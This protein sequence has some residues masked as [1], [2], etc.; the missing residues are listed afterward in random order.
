MQ[1]QELY[2]DQLTTALAQG[3][4][5]QSHFIDKKI[6]MPREDQVTCPASHKQLGTRNVPTS[7]RVTCR[8]FNI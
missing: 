3:Y 5:Y 7:L 2:I 8:L 1:S 6:E 4:C